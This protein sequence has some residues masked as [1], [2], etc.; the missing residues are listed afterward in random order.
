[1][2]DLSAAASR[3][4]ASRTRRKLDHDRESLRRPDEARE[5]ELIT[6]LLSTVASGD[7]EAVMELLAPDIVLLSDGG[8]SRHAAARSELAARGSNCRRCEANCSDAARHEKRSAHARASA[9]S[10]FS[11]CRQASRRSS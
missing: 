8:A 1:M 5:Q 7:I 3:Q 2:V 6:N 10:I 11:A 9:R 4:L